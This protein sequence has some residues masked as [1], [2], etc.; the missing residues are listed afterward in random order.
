MNPPLQ[1]Y[2]SQRQSEFGLISAERQSELRELAE[3]ISQE[4]RDSKSVQLVFICTHNSRRSH[5]AQIWAHTAAQVYGTPGRIAC[6]SGGTEA[7]AF[8]PRAVAALTR[9]GFLI[10]KPDEGQNPVYVVQNEA[11]DPGLRCWSKKYDDAQNPASDFGAVMTCSQADEACPLVK[12]ADYR[13]AVAYDDPK[14]LDGTSRETEAYDERCAQIA[15][16][17]LYCFSQVQV[18]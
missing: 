17:M 12:G 16:E 10:D 3:Y 9:S 13:I 2:I 8:N 18:P 7:T 15:R 14:A 6:Y 5:M 1:K 11:R 4:L